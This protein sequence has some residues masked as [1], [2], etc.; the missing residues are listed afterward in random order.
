M[1]ALRSLLRSAAAPLAIAITAGTASAH[2]GGDHGAHHAFELTLVGLV[3]L[4]A[5]GGLAFVLFKRRR[6]C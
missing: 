1:N 5:A 2:T 6:S 3:A 4:A